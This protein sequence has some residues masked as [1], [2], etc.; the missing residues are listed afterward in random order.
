MITIAGAGVAGLVCAYELARRGARVTVYDKAD[1]PAGNQSSWLAGGMLAPWCEGET[2]EP[3]VVR[4][5]A[6]AAAWWRQ[7]TQVDQRGTLV[8]APRRDRAELDRFARRTQRHRRLGGAEIAGLE[9]ALSGRFSSALFFADEAHL[10]P[11][12]AM[13]NLVDALCDMGVT[14]RYGEPAPEQVTV[15]CRGAGADTPGL[16]RV[17]GE[18]AIIRA[19]EVN[20]SRVVRLLHPRVPVYLVPRGAGV[21]MIGATMVEGGMQGPVTVRSLLELLGA[22]FTLH[23][24]FGEAAV[25]DTA[26]GLRAAFPDNVP[27]LIRRGDTIHVNGLFRHGF[28]IA[29]ALA[30]QL[31]DLLLQDCSH[32]HINDHPSER[33]TTSHHGDHSGRGSGRAWL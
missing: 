9:A 33:G 11:R 12:Q 1:G 2:A 26:A 15:D 18:M 28:L 16:R 3:E 22:A 6:G 20:I 25:V 27:R 32:D 31:A 23:P 7:V 30:S 29:P 8:V 13:Q 14:L 19:P 5:G 17:R 24:A 10:N 4:L 21:Y